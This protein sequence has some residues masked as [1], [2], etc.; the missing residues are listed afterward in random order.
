MEDHDPSAPAG[1]PEVHHMTTPIR[2]AAAEAGDPHGVNLWAGTGYAR[3]VEGA[4]MDILRSLT[5]QTVRKHQV[6]IP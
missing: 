3:T 1:Y 6:F 5:P 2:A 4:A